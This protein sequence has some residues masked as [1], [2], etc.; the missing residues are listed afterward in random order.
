MNPVTYT[1]E[2]GHP[3]DVVFRTAA[4]PEQQLRWD[5]ARMKSLEK[6][7]PGPLAKGARYRASFKGM[8][9]VEYDYEEFD[10]PRRFS[11]RARLPVGTMRHVF[12]FEPA[13]GGTRLTQEGTLEPKTLGRLIAPVMRGMLAKRFSQIAQELDDYLRSRTTA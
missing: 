6:L 9:K 10:P 13:A 5:R 12:S 7:S 8:G 2:L 1:T 3:I 4:D 11:H